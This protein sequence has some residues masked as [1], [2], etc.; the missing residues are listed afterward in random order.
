M[1]YKAVSEPLLGLTDV[2]EAKLG[3]ADAVNQVDGCAA[4]MAL[5]A[6]LE[7]AQH[8][9]EYAQRGRQVNPAWTSRSAVGSSQSV[10]E[11]H[12]DDIKVGRAATDVTLMLVVSVQVM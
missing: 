5:A 11:G 6:D 12:N 7:Q 9:G 4:R 1:L 2:V 8:G 10:A 3:A